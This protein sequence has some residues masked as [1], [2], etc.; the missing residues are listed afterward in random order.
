MAPVSSALM[1]SL[2][3]CLNTGGVH[4]D[5][6]PTAPPPAAPKPATID[7]RKAAAKPRT[8]PSA[9][10]APARAP[11]PTA[12]TGAQTVPSPPIALPDTAPTSTP[13]HTAAV[14]KPPTPITT[15]TAP[16][17]APSI[18]QGTATQ[19]EWV[20]IPAP[21]GI[22]SQDGQAVVLAPGADRVSTSAPAALAALATPVVTPNANESASSPLTINPRPIASRV[23][24][25]WGEAGG[26]SFFNGQEWSPFAPDQSLNQILTVKTTDASGVELELDSR[27][28]LTI[29]GPSRATVQRMQIEGVDAGPGRTVIQLDEGHLIVTPGLP[30]PDGRRAPI[31]VRCGGQVLLLLDATEVWRDRDGSVRTRGLTP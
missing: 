31:A 18:F 15:V 7:L 27:V 22:P 14:R 16:T 29:D 2:T 8:Q 30:G 10:V 1:L 13:P 19:T 23:I 28:R 6:P 21:Q 9:P 4:A 26:A 5:E 24:R 25:V 3:L 17:N 20:G 11:T 12:S